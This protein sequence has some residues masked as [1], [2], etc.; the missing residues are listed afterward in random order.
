MLLTPDLHRFFRK[1]YAELLDLLQC[2]TVLLQA[3]LILCPIDELSE[4]ITTVSPYYSLSWLA[5][6]ASE[7]LSPKDVS[8]LYYD[9]AHVYVYVILYLL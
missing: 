8:V 4:L 9:F 5:Y 6:M 2:D 1:Y 7:N 3:F